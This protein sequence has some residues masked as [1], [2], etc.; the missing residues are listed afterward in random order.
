[1]SSVSFERHVYGVRMVPCSCSQVSNVCFG[2]PQCD[3]LAELNYG[4]WSVKRKEIK[5]L[6]PVAL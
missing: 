5:E 6:H 1:M 4:D 2:L 3:L